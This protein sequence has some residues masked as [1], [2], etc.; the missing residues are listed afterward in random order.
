MPTF[1]AVAAIVFA[2][3]VGSAVATFPV[4]RAA[5]ESTFRGVGTQTAP[6]SQKA[7]SA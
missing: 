7:V 6:K 4:D 3:A 5:V 1:S 2:A